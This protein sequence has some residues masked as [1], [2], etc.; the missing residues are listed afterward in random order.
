MSSNFAKVKRNMLRE[1]NES[2]SHSQQSWAEIMLRGASRCTTVEDQKE[3]FK[4]VLNPHDTYDVPEPTFTV[5]D[6]PDE[7]DVLIPKL[8]RMIISSDDEKNGTVDMELETTE[9][10]N[11]L[12]SYILVT[13]KE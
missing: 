7:T 5:L 1:I 12:T 9:Y 3:F 13:P 6:T 2:H 10:R 11:G 4:F 8:Q